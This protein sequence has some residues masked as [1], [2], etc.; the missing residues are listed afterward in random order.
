MS[1]L[2]GVILRWVERANRVS[3]REA[4]GVRILV[5]SPNGGDTMIGRETDGCHGGPLIYGSRTR[6][7]EDP[8]PC[9]VRERHWDRGSF[10]AGDGV[11]DAVENRV[12]VV[13]GVNVTPKERDPFEPDAELVLVDGV[14]S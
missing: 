4:G 13:S 2:S 8:I 1:G 3:E 5:Y 12:R 6:H 7:G 10:R 14:S 9:E 11:Y